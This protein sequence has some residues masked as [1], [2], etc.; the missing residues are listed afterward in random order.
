MEYT[1]PFHT[2]VLSL[3]GSGKRQ[4]LRLPLPS[5]CLLQAL[6]PCNSTLRLSHPLARLSA[7]GSAHG[8]A[9]GSLAA[10]LD[11]LHHA[12]LTSSSQSF[13]IS[14]HSGATTSGGLPGVLLALEA[15]CLPVLPS[16]L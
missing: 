14:W 12:S 15:A 3:P 13:K 16:P 7:H 8:S 11:H 2:C 4:A 5:L 6:C 1:E 9:L 10:V